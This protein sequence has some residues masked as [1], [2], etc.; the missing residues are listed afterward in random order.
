[1][2][3]NCPS[4][5]HQKCQTEGLYSGTGLLSASLIFFSPVSVAKGPKFRPQNTKGAEKN[6][7]GPEKSGAEFSAD[8]SIKGR[9]GAEVS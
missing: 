6:S 9:K 1:M 5:F 3:V 2:F 8:L 7:M 4:N